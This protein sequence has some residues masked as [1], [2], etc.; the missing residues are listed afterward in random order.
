LPPT[1]NNVHAVAEDGEEKR[2]DIDRSKRKRPRNP[3]LEYSIAMFEIFVVA[4]EIN[5]RNME[6][7]GKRKMKG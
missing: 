2:V 6:R 4:E 1:S 3:L 5:L 7:V